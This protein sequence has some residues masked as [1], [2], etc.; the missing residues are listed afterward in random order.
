MV[1]HHH[2]HYLPSYPSLPPSLLGKVSR[3]PLHL[4]T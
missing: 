2:P 3:K 1:S 4:L